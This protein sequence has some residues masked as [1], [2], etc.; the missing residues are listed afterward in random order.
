MVILSKMPVEL[1][2]GAPDPN[3][4]KGLLDA[5]EGMAVLTGVDFQAPISSIQS[6]YNQIY[7]EPTLAQRL[8]DVYPSRGIFKEAAFRMPDVDQKVPFDLSPQRLCALLKNDEELIEDLGVDFWN[9]LT[10]YKHVQKEMI[11]RLLEL[12]AQ[13]IAGGCEGQDATDLREKHKEENHNY[14]LVDY[15]PI[16]EGRRCGEH[17]DYGTFTLIFQDG[18]VGGLEIFQNG[19][20]TQIPKDAPVIFLW[21]WSAT[22]L[23]NG[24]IQAPLHR[25]VPNGANDGEDSFPRKNSA[26]FFVAPDLDAKLVPVLI[27]PNEKLS[28]HVD[29]V[30]NL[31]VREFKQIMGKKWRKREGTL[32]AQEEKELAL[33]D[34]NC[35]SQDEEIQTYLREGPGV[36]SV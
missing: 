36:S 32:S 12:T 3:L 7:N 16:E 24:R 17:R 35:I 30:T 8:N 19:A 10:F 25:V 27:D 28:F 21:G 1:D 26:I 22:I 29:A 4:M 5:P 6:L 31:T 34:R 15:Y 14:R 33:H 18:K 13:A 20:W 2:W 23:S 11:P 9:I